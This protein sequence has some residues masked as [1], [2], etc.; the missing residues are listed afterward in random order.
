[1]AN[2]VLPQELG[3]VAAVAYVK[4]YKMEADLYALPPVPRLPDGFTALPWSGDLLA[5]HADVLHD[6]FHREFDARVF[7]SFRDRVGCVSLMT[8]ISRRLGFLPEATW[9]L[10]GP[11]GPCG[12][13]QGLRERGAVGAVQNV[14]VAPAWRG[15]GLGEALLLLAL[16]GF[17]RAGLAV[18][19]LE[20]TAGNDAAVRLYRRLGFRFRKTLYKAIPDIND[21]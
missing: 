20:V 16:H 1:V 17:L 13:V 3:R 5:A 12:S 4:R 15:R 21:P 9:L 18:G 7:P 8:A 14:G 19:L 6:S 11:A 10:V 2:S